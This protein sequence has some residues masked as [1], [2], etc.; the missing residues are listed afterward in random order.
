MT[1]KIVKEAQDFYADCE[2]A[3]S[4]QRSM[5]LEDIKFARLAEQWESGVEESRSQE[6]RPMLTINKCPQFARQ[7]INN[8]RQNKPAIKVHPVDDFADTETADVMNGMIR[9][10]E[11]T[12]DAEVAYDTGLENAVYGGIGYF[13][14]DVDYAS[15]DQFDLDIFINRIADPMSVWPDPETETYDA[16]DWN[17]CLIESTLGK[18]AFE[19]KYPKAE[20]APFS[21]DTTEWLTEDEVKI[22]EFWK[23][24][25]RTVD[26]LQLSDGTVML[27]DQYEKNQELFY[28]A[29]LVVIKTRPTLTHDVIQYILSGHQ[30]LEKTEWVG[31]YIPIVPVY[32]EEFTVEGKRYFKSMFRD[33]KDAQRMFNY[34]RTASTELVALAPKA[35]YVGAVGQFASDGRK[36]ASAN[37]QSHP[38]LEY[39]LVTTE[40][41]QPAPPPQRQP[42]AGPP[43]GAIQE[44][45]NAADDMKSILGMH[46]PA[47]GEAT[48]EI[49]S[50]R[51]IGKEQ[52]VGDISNFHFVDNLSR[53]MRYAG[54]VLLDLIPQVY[55]TPRMLRIMGQDGS[56]DSVAINQ[57]YE[58]GGMTKI[59]DMS[60]GKY[61]LTISV[62]ASYNTKRE[63]AVVTLTR[64]VEAAPQLM[65]V[66]GDLIAQNMDWDGADEMAR[67]LKALLPPQVQA[68]EELEGIPDEAKVLVSQAQGQV[69][70]LQ[71]TIEQGKMVLAEK[72]QQITELNRQ[73][74]DKA[75]EHAIKHKQISAE[76]LQTKMKEV[77]DQQLEFIKQQLDYQAK[78]Q[79]A[80]I[81]STLKQ[82]EGISGLP[83]RES[84]Q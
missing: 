30:E 81:Q 62:G 71:Q 33:A 59:H 63:E 45:I 18:E 70:Q 72:D 79:M 40:D 3:W 23:R 73:L 19:A 32:G 13:R 80:Y 60:K 29:G 16:S 22:A 47:I 5:A 2:D 75:D 25:E 50:G 7:V 67:R 52:R 26:L 24:T 56:V 58:K 12:S 17:R 41:G 46:D 68:L 74:K 78:E 10:I 61:D 43:G 27:Q 34:W 1:D 36:W 54:R 66:I 8:A 20:T 57:Q 55:S 37:V 4:E 42:F 35:P 64:I 48:D 51:A 9:N 49:M 76:V 65:G 31:R 53:S 83:Q 77:G 39:D 82:L 44:A 38:Y 6:K 11:Y 14:I 69:K 84:V 15:Y 28:E 21:T